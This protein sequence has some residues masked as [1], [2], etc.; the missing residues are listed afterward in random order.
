MAWRM[1]GFEN[2]RPLFG[3]FNGWKA[4][5]G[6]EACARANKKSGKV[7]PAET[8]IGRGARSWAARR[9][10]SI[11]DAGEGEEPQVEGRG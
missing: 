4:H 3:G 1:D 9:A 8:S 11:G 6:M 10:P 2:V 7:A 5:G